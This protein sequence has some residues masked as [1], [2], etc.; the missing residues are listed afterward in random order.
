[1][2]NHR[3]QAKKELRDKEIEFEKQMLE[4]E[5]QKQQDNTQQKREELEKFRNE[6]QEAEDYRAFLKQVE[7]DKEK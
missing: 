3:E 5:M 7:E 4:I 1:M 2:I 6:I